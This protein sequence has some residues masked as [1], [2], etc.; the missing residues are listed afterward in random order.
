MSSVTPLRLGAAVVGGAP[1]EHFNGLIDEVRVAQGAATGS[2]IQADYLRS[3]TFGRPFQVELSTTA[4]SSWQIFSSTYHVA[5]STRRVVEM[6]G[7][8][9]QTLAATITVYGLDFAKSEPGA[10]ATNQL[11]F[12]AY[13]KAGKEIK[14]AVR[15][16][17]EKTTVEAEPE[18]KQDPAHRKKRVTFVCMGNACRS[19]MAAG[20][21]KKML[22]EAEVSGV[23]VVSAGTAALEGMPATELAVKTA[24][25]WGIQISS[26]RSRP[27]TE[28]LVKEADLILTMSPEH[29]EEVLLFDSGAANKTFLLK[30]FPEPVKADPAFS[31]RDPIGGGASD[32]QRSFFE[33]E[34]S[35]RRIFSLFLQRA[36]KR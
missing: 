18:P 21:L 31:V 35:L 26:H 16:A 13:D 4:G 14:E 27:V 15:A 20:I 24:A 34:E 5:G 1:G 25:E 19:P 7:G 12:T 9:W 28:E 3:H 32:Y 36:G 30:S 8:Q 11:R 17:I 33:I 22:A 10:V 29:R 2:E 23:A 6:T